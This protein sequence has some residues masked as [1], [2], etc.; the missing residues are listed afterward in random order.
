MR[1]I[2]L[3]LIALFAT[4]AFAGKAKPTYASESD[5]FE[6]GRNFLRSHVAVTTEDGRTIANT[7]DWSRH[8]PINEDGCRPRVT[9]KKKTILT[10]FTMS[11]PAYWGSGQRLKFDFVEVTECGH[12]CNALALMVV[13]VNDKPLRGKDMADFVAKPFGVYPTFQALLS[14]PGTRVVGAD[15][16]EVGLLAPSVRKLA[17]DG[18]VCELTGLDPDSGGVSLLCVRG[19]NTSDPRSFDYDFVLA[20][21]GSLAVQ[22][23]HVRGRDKPGMPIKKANELEGTEL[24][25]H[26]RVNFGAR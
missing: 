1:L 11:C 2:V 21:D 22:G 10:I 26:A 7:E 6:I 25:E 3:L 16:K 12:A 13:T 24:I 14:N 19:Q 4:P 18:I 9:E 15:G 5:P 20:K 23:A 17:K 8:F